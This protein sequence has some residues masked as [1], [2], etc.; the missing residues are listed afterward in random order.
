MNCQFIVEPEE[1]KS[2]HLVTQENFDII[3]KYDCGNNP[4]LISGF[5]RRVSVHHPAPSH[6]P[7]SPW[8]FTTAG[9][10]N[11]YPANP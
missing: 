2:I 10:H 3:Q 7:R 4:K 9:G 5:V 6:A 11:N 1:V 8:L